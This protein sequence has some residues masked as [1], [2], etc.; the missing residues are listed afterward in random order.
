MY[1]I[2]IRLKVIYFMGMHLMGAGPPRHPPRP[3]ELAPELARPRQTDNLG[4]GVEGHCYG[5]LFQSQLRTTSACYVLRT[6]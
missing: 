6:P 4:C 2:G 1:L 5:E 3:P